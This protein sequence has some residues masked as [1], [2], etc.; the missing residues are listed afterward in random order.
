MVD[1]FHHKSMEPLSLCY[2]SDGHFKGHILPLDDYDT[3]VRHYPIYYQ[4]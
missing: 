4:A 1:L 3:F 2:V